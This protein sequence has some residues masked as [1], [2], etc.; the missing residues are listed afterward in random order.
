MTPCHACLRHSLDCVYTPTAASR[1]TDREE[2]ST[3]ISAR[4]L[5]AA[6]DA[7]NIAKTIASKKQAI[8]DIKKPIIMA[9][10]RDRVAVLENDI[11][12]LANVVRTGNRRTIFLG[13]G[14]QAHIANGDTHIETTG[15]AVGVAKFSGGDTRSSE[16][17]GKGKPFM[18]DA[19]PE[20]RKVK[21]RYSRRYANTLPFGFG[22]QL[23]KNLPEELRSQ[24]QI[25]R[26]QL[27]GWNMS[28]GHYIKPR[29]IPSPISLLDE[30]TARDLLAYFFENINP[31]HT[32]LHKPMFMEQYDVYLITP[33]K[34]QCRLFLANFHAVCAIT[35]RFRE[36]CDNA[37]FDAGLE[38]KLFDDAHA[39]LQAFAFEWES[40]EIVQG[41]LLLAV[42][43][44]A[45][46]RQPSV[47]SA[48]GCAIRMASGMGLMHKID[49]AIGLSSYEVLKRNRVF[50]ACFVLDRTLCTESGRHFS[51]C[52]TDISIPIPY[53]YMDDGWQ[54]KISSAL[55]QLC[56]ALVDLIYD[57]TLELNGEEI[58]ST[59]TRLLAWNDG[60]GN[61]G[62]DSDTELDAYKDFPVP[63]VAHFRLCYY[64]ALFYIHMRA[65]FGLAGIEWDSTNI[66]RQLYMDCVTGVTNIATS[67]YELD[68]LK[69]PWWL[70]LS[71]LYHAG[72]VALL[73]IYQQIEM[74]QMGKE[75]AKIVE[76]VSVIAED[77]RF[78]M[79][80]ECVWSLKTLNHMV[81]MKLRQT[82]AIIGGAGLDH[83]PAAV[84][85]GNFSSMGFLDGQGNEILPVEEEKKKEKPPRTGSKEASSS[86]TTPSVP[87]STTDVR[88]DLF[89]SP[90]PNPLSLPVPPPHNVLLEQHNDPIMSLQWF[91]NWD[92]EIQDYF[93][94]PLGL[95]ASDNGSNANGNTP[96][97]NYSSRP[98]FGGANTSTPSSTS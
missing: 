85:K 31:L 65:V 2:D 68:Q 60:L 71:T 41:Y 6:V 51:F 80:R 22:K 7:A 48:L 42:Y 97:S 44:R 86:G 32:I 38:E 92:W 49:D 79:A 37:K 54:T 88:E 27:Y 53:T 59:K 50:W 66:D 70:L 78:I 11:S 1:F 76:L 72:C 67:L 95:D 20:S 91:D 9:K 24:V 57:R 87:S 52:E 98:S 25:P 56:L 28:G 8:M 19:D 33:N 93:G 39:T 47:W 82:M 94:D 90:T 45:C 43:L 3:V 69:S 73:L 64:N 75:F 46:H 35:I 89:P 14:D 55:L 84:N 17:Y 61:T 83:G 58:V 23:V 96:S 29:K 62:L 30:T 21:F 4:T 77:G 63:L 34:Q 74:E 81:F 16:R 12:R 15:T 13:G 36:V 40:I 26:T 10:L 18:S 5:S